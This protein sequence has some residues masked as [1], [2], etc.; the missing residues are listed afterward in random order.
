MDKHLTYPRLY[1][2]FTRNHWQTSFSVYE[3]KQSDNYLCW[4]VSQLM[5]PVRYRDLR[6]KKQVKNRTPI[7]YW[8]L[9]SDEKHNIPLIQIRVENFTQFF[10]FCI[11]K[12]AKYHQNN[13]KL[14]QYC[15][16]CV[17][18]LSYSIAW[19]PRGIGL[20]PVKVRTGFIKPIFPFT[21]AKNSIM[22]KICFLLRLY[23]PEIIVF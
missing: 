17:F 23:T 7:N 21:L 6:K 11:F 1:E 3:N 10:F 2:C 20:F 15:A 8:K 13:W 16:L 22:I 14:I 19:S 4:I 12:E 5:A 18:F 9:N